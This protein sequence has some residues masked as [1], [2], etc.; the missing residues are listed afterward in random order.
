MKLFIAFNIMLLI[1]ALRGQFFIWGNSSDALGEQVVLGYA[2]FLVHV[3]FFLTFANYLIVKLEE[4]RNKAE[5][6]L[7]FWILAPYMSLTWRFKYSLLPV[8]SDNLQ[9][10]LAIALLSAWWLQGRRLLDGFKTL[11]LL[12]FQ[13]G[14]SELIPGKNLH[15]KA[16]FMRIVLLILVFLPLPFWGVSSLFLQID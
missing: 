1:Y 15:D 8:F 9:L 6:F 16:V 11:A 12:G 13:Q 2:A 14:E 4:G 5:R 3:L 10:L 7:V